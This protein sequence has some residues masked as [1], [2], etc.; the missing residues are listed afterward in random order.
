MNEIRLHAYAKVNLGLDVLRRREDGYH[1][2]RMVM[3]N[4]DLY[5]KVSIK[6]IKTKEIILKTNLTYL[7]IDEN[8]LV[9]RA[10]KLLMDEFDIQSGVYIDLYKFIPV[11]AGMAGGSADAAA[12]LYGMNELFN[13]NLTIE[14]LMERGVKLGADIPFCLMGGT[15]LAEGIGEKLTRLKDCPKTYMVVAKP[16][17]SVSTKFV[18]ENLKLDD[19]TKHPDIDGIL[20][21][22]EEQDI[23][24]VCSRLENVLE[25]VTAKQYPDIETIK[26]TMRDNGAL[27]SLMSGSGPTV[28]GVFD[29]EEKAKKCNELLRNNKL[30][31]TCYVVKTC[32]GKMKGGL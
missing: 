15:V 2:V 19:N 12:T 13:L 24:G 10:C 8:N 6:K 17:F 23:Y 14:Q 1:D 5:D 28:F 18:Y 9:Y 31:K 27:N 4:V 21:A 22:I 25:T 30:V 29:D 20:K 16:P 7:P 11:A 26:K 32:D 3:Q